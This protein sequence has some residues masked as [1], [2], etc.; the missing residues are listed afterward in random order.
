[1]LNYKK[2]PRIVSI[3][4]SLKTH[5]KSCQYCNCDSN[6]SARTAE[7]RLEFGDA[8]LEEALAVECGSL[9]A[10]AGGGERQVGIESVLGL[11]FVLPEEAVGVR[12]ESESRE[13]L[14][15]HLCRTLHRVVRI[16]GAEDRVEHEAKT[17]LDIGRVRA[18]IRRAD[19]DSAQS[20]PFL[21]LYW[22]LTAQ[23]LGMDMRGARGSGIE[24]LLT[25]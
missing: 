21:L 18:E 8:P 24:R 22:C 15:G 16:G 12:E 25:K 7:P 14:R 13:K 1:M 4:S 2:T 23:T 3:L 17:R 20:A 11:E 9:F 10:C 5:Y 19:A 6:A